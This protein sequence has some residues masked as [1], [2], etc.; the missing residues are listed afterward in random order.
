MDNFKDENGEPLPFVIKSISPE[1][2]EAISK[3]HTDSDGKFDSI[4]YGNELM[5]ACMVEPDL[6]DSEL[7][8]FYGVMD[9]V[10]VPSRMFTI[11]EKQIIQGNVLDLN[12]LT[13]AADKLKSAKNS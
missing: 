9:P 6:K 2:N 5:V 12:D 1:E 11:G 8:K 4:G 3:K 13:S 7:C 10:M